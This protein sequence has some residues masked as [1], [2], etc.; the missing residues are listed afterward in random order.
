MTRIGSAVWNGG[1]VDG[2]G[3]V[4][5]E[6][7]VLTGIPY[8]FTSRFEHGTG[9]NPEELLGAAHA[10]CF[11]MALS[12]VLGESQI[13][14]DSIET[15]AAVTVEKIGDGFSITSVALKTT[16]SAP[17]ADKDKVEA[18]IQGAK[19]GCPVSKLFN[20][21]ITIESTVNV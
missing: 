7:G 20:T 11:S 17:G 13:K 10:G 6:S 16:V 19:A 12:A 3:V 4:S 8:S 15:S 18:A 1:L 21:T 2:K 9:T 5:T 14:A